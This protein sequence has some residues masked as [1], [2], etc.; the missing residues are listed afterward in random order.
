MPRAAVATAVPDRVRHALLVTLIV[1]AFT[2]ASM[3]A[4]AP[5]A[6]AIVGGRLAT[7]EYTNMAAFLDNGNQVCGASLIAPQWVVSA[8]HC[9]GPLNASRYSFRIGGT[10]DLAE[11][12]G[13]TIQ[14]TK[15]IV[16]PDYDG[17]YDVSL[18]KLA[19]PSIYEPIPIAQPATDRDLWEPGDMARVIGYGGQFFQLPSIDQQ[20]RE[21]DVPIVDD[22]ECDSSYVLSGGIDPAV[23]VCAGEL[24]GTKDSCQGDSGGPLMVRDEQ[25]ELVQM[26][27]VS[28]GFGCGFPTQYGVYSRIGA[29]PLYNWI[30]ST[31]A[32][33]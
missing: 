11:P 31:I 29:N 17:T 18:F 23:E 4:M 32:T 27:V 5:R 6:N 28:W 25:G 19:R 14:A 15:V 16:H 22:S 8:A 1:I 30:Q 21:V 10:P 3:A 7:E 9:V 26:G 13:E 24:L 20:L 12:G 33:N 2:V